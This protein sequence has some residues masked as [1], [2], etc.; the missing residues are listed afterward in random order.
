MERRK[1]VKKAALGVAAGGVLAGCGGEAASG[2][3]PAVQT[4]ARVT[5]RLASSFPRSLDTIYGAA[6]VLA[7][8][9]AKLTGDRF[10]IRA[11][12]GGELVP[13]LEVLSAVQKGTV[14]LAHTASY[15]FKGLDPALIFDCSVPFGLTA[16]Q[17]NAWL[18]YGGGL[19]LLRKRF[20]DFNVI[21]FPGGN[22]GVQ[23]GGWFRDPISTAADLRGL[24]MRIPGL[25]GE[26]MAR[27]GVNVQNLAGGEIYPALERGV[28]DATEW[29]GPYDDEKLGF[30][31][32]VKNYYYPGWWEP[33]PSLSFYV[34][35]EAWESLPSLYQE[36]FQ[37]AA[38]EANVRMMAQYD[39][40]NPPAVQRLREEGVQ[41]RP[42]SNDIMEAARE[43]TQALLQEQAAAEAGFREIYEAWREWRTSAFGWFGTAEQGFSTFAFGG[44]SGD[45]CAI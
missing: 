40:V 38:A 31:Q 34:N 30:H 39:A 35:T 18:Y 11:Y 10:R 7:D 16:R 13:A 28:I 26:V 44:G 12:P 22:T 21:H 32:I 29:V 14:Q 43:Q 24:R 25:G 36:A 9:V 42:F 41:F 33:G 6:E 20:A 1:F 8:R 23:M 37:S 3:A 45:E 2:G 19:D 4:G 27:L 17:Q 5:W 15:Y